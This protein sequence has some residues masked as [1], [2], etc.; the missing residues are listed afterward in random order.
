MKRIMVATDGSDGAAR[1]IG[2]A[3]QLARA[4]DGDLRVVNVA[5][6]YGLPGNELEGFMRTEGV[7]IYQALAAESRDILTRGEMQARGA[8]AGRITVESRIGDAAE[9]L[10]E[11]AREQKVDAIVIGKRGR[12]SLKGL[13]LGS[14]SHKLVTLAPCAV[15]VVP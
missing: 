15:I 8:G 4:F 5:P 13:L 10:L 7:S 3:A 9:A 11:I 1:A 12:G 2:F 14:V 6:S